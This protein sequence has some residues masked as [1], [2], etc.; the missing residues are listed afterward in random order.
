MLY[1]EEIEGEL[2]FDDGQELIIGTNYYNWTFTPQDTEK[3]NVITGQISI[4]VKAIVKFYSEGDL[5]TT[6]AVEKDDTISVPQVPTKDDFEGYTYAFSHW[7]LTQGGDAFNFNSE[8]ET[9][10]D[11]Y[12]VFTKSNPIEY[13][14]TYDLNG[15]LETGKQNPTTYTIESEDIVLNNPVRDAYYFAGWTGSNGTVP[16]LEVTIPSGTTGNKSYIANWTKVLNIENTTLV[17]VTTFGKTLS[18]I[19]IPDWVTTIKD[20]AFEGCTSLTNIT[21]PNGIT[22]VGDY[23]FTDC[24]SLN[25]NIYDNACYLGSQTN[26]YLLLIKAKNISITD[27]TISSNCKFVCS[28]AFS[29]CESLAGI[30]IPSNISRVGAKA[31]LGC[32]AL[33]DITIQNGVS[34]IGEYAFRNC[35]SLKSIVIPNSMSSID[36]CVFLSCHLL[37]NITLPDSIESIGEM[38]FGE[39]KKMESITL[40]S[41]L[42]RIEDFTFSRSGLKSIVLPNKVTS[43]GRS[44]FMECTALTSIVIPNNVTIIGDFAFADCS[45][46]TSITIPNNVTVI[47]D[48]VFSNCS[49]LASITVPNSITSIGYSAFSKCGNLTN[50]VFNGTT[51]R[52]NSISKNYDWNKNTGNYTIYCTDGNIS[53]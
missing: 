5:Y 45:E 50:I 28:N 30:E 13:S 18:E 6:I 44:A 39:C 25:Y 29:G 38:A 12:A 2:V 47:S 42:T 4:I 10:M 23:V 49:K 3:Y 21:I 53:K 26:P 27:C 15:K 41:S 24:T 35:T 33:S 46:L 16:Q 36:R 11:L 17:S 52:W 32:T 22:N 48:Y 43:I 14:I 8:V 1:D 40:P 31:F 34:S 19:I 51:F 20:Y 37:E 9:N 7:S